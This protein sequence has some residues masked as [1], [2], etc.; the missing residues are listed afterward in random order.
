MVN[1]RIGI[2][3]FTGDA[4]GT[5]ILP[6]GSSRAALRVKNFRHSVDTLFAIGFPFSTTEIKVT[7]YEWH[8]SES[9]NPVFGISY[10]EINTNGSI[11]IYKQVGYNIESPTDVNDEP[12]QIVNGF[13][14]FQNY[15]NPFNPSTK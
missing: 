4:Y 11:S 13:E 1:R 6:D 9:K 10:F 15:P 8:T 12:K 5:I 3:Q 7:T 2:N 14:L